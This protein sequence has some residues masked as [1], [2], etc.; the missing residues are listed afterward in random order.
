MSGG[1][2]LRDAA[3][4]ARRMELG[5]ILCEVETFIRRYVVL[6]EAAAAIAAVWIAHVFAFAA[7]EFTAYLIVTSA[8]KR[9]GKSRLLE[10]IEVILGALAVSTANISPASLFRLI[11]ANPG[12][13]VL[14]VEV[15]RIPK[16]KAEDLLGPD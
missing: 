13:A 1:E 12:V 10:V 3:P 14:F 2:F 8:T 9:A 5:E 11:D 16:E 4:P 15:D 6:S 7:F